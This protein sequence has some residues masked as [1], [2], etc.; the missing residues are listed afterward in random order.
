MIKI[1]KYHHSKY[2]Y[3][4][5]FSTASNSVLCKQVEWNSIQLKA[6]S[7]WIP[8]CLWCSKKGRVVKFVEPTNPNNTKKTFESRHMREREGIVNKERVNF[9]WWWPISWLSCNDLRLLHS[10]IFSWKPPLPSHKWLNSKII[11]HLIK[12]MNPTNSTMASKIKRNVAK[13]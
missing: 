3:I 9:L 1:E 12:S 2:I 8:Y 6:S 4:Y 7:I 11:L 5:H 13:Y 10:C